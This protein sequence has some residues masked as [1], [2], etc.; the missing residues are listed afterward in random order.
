MKQK[1][2]NEQK[3][4][5]SDLRCF[6]SENAINEE[7]EKLNLLLDD[8]EKD[9]T[10]VNEDNI[11]LYYQFMEKE[12]LEIYSNLLNDILLNRF[13]N[14]RNTIKVKDKKFKPLK[15]YNIDLAEKS[16]NYIYVSIFEIKDTLK[17]IDEYIAKIKQSE[18]YLQYIKNKA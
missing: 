16:N 3:K 6:A 18:Q 15:D 2:I 5:I 4:I 10:L 11:H 17:P 12:D 9:N 1:A 8:F 7:I 14:V 13:H